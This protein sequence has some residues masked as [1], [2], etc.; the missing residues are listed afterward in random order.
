M[1]ESDINDIEAAVLGDCCHVF[2]ERGKSK[3]TPNFLAWTVERKVI[4]LPVT[5]SI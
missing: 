1:D 4:L 3:M 2:H 5:Q